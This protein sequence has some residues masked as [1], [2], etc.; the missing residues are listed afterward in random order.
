ML[1]VIERG[2]ARSSVEPGRL[3]FEVTETAAIANMPEATQ[4]A[5]GLTT[6]GCSLAL[7]DFGTSAPS[8][9]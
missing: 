1:G 8:T 2:L 6:L 9:T 3:I 4:F 7:D 5:R